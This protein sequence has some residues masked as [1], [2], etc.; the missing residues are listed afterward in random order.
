MLSTDD[1]VKCFVSAL[2]VVRLVEMVNWYVDR[3]IH[4]FAN[5]VSVSLN[6]QLVAKLVMTLADAKKNEIAAPLI[7]TST[8]G[9]PTKTPWQSSSILA[10]ELLYS[11]G[12]RKCPILSKGV[13]GARPEH[14]KEIAPAT[15]DVFSPNSIAATASRYDHSTDA[16]RTID[17]SLSGNMAQ[18][19]ATEQET[20]DSPEVANLPIISPEGVYAYVPCFWQ[21]E[22]THMLKTNC[23]LSDQL[24]SLPSDAPLYAPF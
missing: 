22:H 11:I 19:D 18:S 17:L 21:P 2:V 3:A 14:E 15:V 5:Q 7:P 24:G 20:I 23:N 12:S 4:R 6:E 10:D 8:P 13:F 16:V 9:V 1:I